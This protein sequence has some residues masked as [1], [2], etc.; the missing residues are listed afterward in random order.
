VNEQRAL[1]D[2]TEYLGRLGYGPEMIK[3]EYRTES[4]NYIDLLVKRSDENLIAVEVKQPQSDVF[5]IR[6]EELAFHPIA[7]LLQREAT[8]LGARHYIISNGTKHIWL[9]NGDNGRPLVVEAVSFEEISSQKLEDTE[10]VNGL[11]NHV[12]SYLESHPITGDLS[13]DFSVAIYTKLRHDLGLPGDINLDTLPTYHAERHF[14]PTDVVL[15]EISRKWSD[16]DFLSHKKEVF[17]YIDRFLGK[18]RMEWQVPRWLSD[19]MVE[20]YPDGAPKELALDLF[21]RHGVIVSS[22]YNDGWKEVYGYFFDKSTEYWVK[23][24]QLLSS[25]SIGTC[26]FDADLLSTDSSYIRNAGKFDCVFLAPPFG[27]KV[28]SKYDLGK[29]DAWELL[30]GKSLEVTKSSGYVIV[31][32]PDGALL[33]SRYR[34]FREFVVTSAYLTGVISLGQETFKPY[35]NVST[36]ILVIKKEKAENRESFLGALDDG[37]E[38]ENRHSNCKKLLEN[39]SLFNLGKPFEPEEQGFKTNELDIDN[40]HYSNYLFSRNQKMAIGLQKGYRAVPLKEVVS[41]IQRGRPYKQDAANDVPYL[42]PAAIRSMEII[43]EA[44]SFTSKI[45]EPENP[46]LAYENDIVINIIGTHRGSAAPVGRNCDRLGIS[47]HLV[48][49][50]P[51][52]NVVD[53]YYLA[54]ALNS[55]YVQE[56]LQEGSRG[57]VIPSLSL[58]SFESIFIPLPPMADQKRTSN[59]YRSAVFEVEEKKNELNEIRNKLKKIQAEIGKESV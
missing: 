30:V 38:Q 3:Y 5:Q 46:V 7:R 11:L 53:P 2:L 6:T 48:L 39:W 45:I 14:D 50:R 17:N 12:A 47:H 51:N 22:A 15:S 28:D 44:L 29:Q 18:N 36:S 35:S 19:F 23:A 58:K 20:L 16:I 4:G 59:A 42:A 26:E 40:L 9:R 55:D 43:E 1:A 24:Q 49:I 25:G 33:S 8:R 13:F 21:A 34:K 56:Q 32:V 10:L 31:I 27:L 41:K 54:I 57:T 37:G 52:T